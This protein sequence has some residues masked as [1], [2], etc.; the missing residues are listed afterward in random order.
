MCCFTRERK[1]KKR[2]LG[3]VHMMPPIHGVLVERAAFPVG[4]LPRVSHRPSVAIILRIEE[5]INIQIF[6]ENN[7]LTAEPSCRRLR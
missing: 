4:T 7:N 5:S 6:T 1:L 3:K 2:R